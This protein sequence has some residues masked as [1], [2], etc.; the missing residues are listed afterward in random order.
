[1]STT[2]LKQVQQGALPREWSSGKRLVFLAFADYFN[3]KEKKAWA[4]I[5]KLMIFTGLSR[6]TFYKYQKEL[7][8]EGYLTQLT[9]GHAG[10]R[11]E[12]RVHLPPV[13]LGERLLPIEHTS[14]SSGSDTQDFRVELDGKLNTTEKKKESDEQDPKRINKNT[15]LTNWKIDHQRFAFVLSNVPQEIRNS[16]TPGTNFE[17]LLDGLMELG[18]VLGEIRTHLAAQDWS[19]STNPGG[20]MQSI[21]R[22]FLFQKAKENSRIPV[23]NKYENA[24]RGESFADALARL[25]LLTKIPN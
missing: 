8:R 2:L 23:R 7:L 25:N 17:A 6:S 10:Q 15:N 12:F 3:D 9:H 24:S 22:K 16:I 1:M 13:P 4:G 5:E 11:A 18:V 20:L 19:T 21:L 14:K